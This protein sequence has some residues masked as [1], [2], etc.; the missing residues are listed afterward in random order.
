MND[1]AF[2]KNYMNICRYIRSLNLL[3]QSQFVF[4]MTPAFTTGS[5]VTEWLIKA[6]LVKWSWSDGESIS[7]DSQD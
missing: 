4:P 6:F 5:K 1:V 3:C 7:V 2:K